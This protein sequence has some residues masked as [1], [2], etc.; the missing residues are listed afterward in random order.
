LI[1][2]LSTRDKFCNAPIYINC[3]RRPKPEP[4]QV[5]LKAQRVT[6]L[7]DHF[8]LSRIERYYQ[9]LQFYLG[10]KSRRARSLSTG[11][12]KEG[13]LKERSEGD[14]ARWQTALGEVM[15]AGSWL[16]SSS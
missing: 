5:N 1:E 9:R 15:A 2:L 10:F 8:T 7:T 3:H 12:Q 11:L 4:Q 13:Q 6:K 14:Q 16:T